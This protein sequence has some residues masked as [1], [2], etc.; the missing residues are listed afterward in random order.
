MSTLCEQTQIKQFFIVSHDYILPVLSASAAISMMIPIYIY[1]RA[2]YLGKLKSTKLKHKILFYLGLCQFMMVLIAYILMTIRFPTD[3]MCN[4][5]R[6]FFNLTTAGILL[7]TLQ[8][9]LLLAIL[10]HRLYAVFDKTSFAMQKSTRT[11]FFV[12]LSISYIVAYVGYALVLINEEWGVYAGLMALSGIVTV[13]MDVWLMAMFIFKLFKVHRAVEW[14]HNNTKLLHVV[15]KTSVLCLISSINIM[16]TIVSGICGIIF[17]SAYVWFIYD[18]ATIADMYSSFLCIYLS[19]SHFSDSYDKICALCHSKCYVF[20]RKCV[21]NKDERKLKEQIAS[22]DS[23]SVN[24]E[25]TV[26]VNETK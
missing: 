18:V 15:T 24:I 14:K 2:Y 25:T 8:N 26:S 7:Y 3:I 22:V 13:M 23:V 1:C 6:I 21:D 19:Y 20:W 16:L 9:L 4:H 11:I 10:F 17:D 12:I 5:K